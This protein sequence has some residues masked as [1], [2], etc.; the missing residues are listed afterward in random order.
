MG[1]K[2]ISF[3]ITLEEWKAWKALAE[4]NHRSLTAQVRQTMNYVCAVPQTTT[5]GEIKESLD[6]NA[7]R[8]SIEGL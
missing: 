5:M 4:S 3:K 8:D 6:G 1:D 7:D 2:Y